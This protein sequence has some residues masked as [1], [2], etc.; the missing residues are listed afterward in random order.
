MNKNILLGVSIG[1]GSVLLIL[2]LAVGGYFLYQSTFNSQNQDDSQSNTTSGKI[3]GKLA[4]SLGVVGVSPS[5]YEDKF[6][7]F[8]NESSE[9]L[10]LNRDGDFTDNVLRIYDLVS[11]ELSVTLLNGVVP[12]LYEDQM[13]FH[14]NEK[15]ENEDL[16]G[17]GDIKDIVIR[18][19]DT[20]L[21][22]ISDIAITGG[23]PAIDG[24]II[25]YHVYERW[26]DD[27]LNGD[28]DQDDFVIHYY[29]IS[30]NTQINTKIEGS[31][32]SISG[33]TIAFH[34]FEVASDTDLNNDG[35]ANDVLIKLFDIETNQLIDPKL[36]GKYPQLVGDVLVFEVSESMYQ[37]DFN[38]D[39]DMTDNA[40]RFYHL[41]TEQLDEKILMGAFVEF[42]GNAIVYSAQELQTNTDL[43]KDDDLDDFVIQIYDIG[44]Q[45]LTQTGIAGTSPSLYGN[46]IV[47]YTN[48]AWVN[49]DLNNNDIIGDNVLQYYEIGTN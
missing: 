28:E 45:E 16:N 9:G 17:D 20:A 14:T 3:S 11:K 8:T 13:L 34:Q 31:T 1:V 36:F 48:E 26:V 43:N 46:K 37:I 5:I 24:D 6:V 44:S 10:D 47:F 30:N 4:N 29:N 40:V 2:G 7:F 42:D 19:Y 27:D 15:D 32:A 18:M 12:V 39:Q 35:D 22:R 41:D 21:G 23:F 25:A 38:E 33:N 49:A